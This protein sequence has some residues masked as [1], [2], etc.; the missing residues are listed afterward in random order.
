MPPKTLDQEVSKLNDGLV[1]V[2][3][4]QTT[5]IT[6]ITPKEQGKTWEYLP[7][8]EM[9]AT[10][11][12][13]KRL[14]EFLSQYYYWDESIS[15]VTNEV[16]VVDLNQML[17]EFEPYEDFYIALSS[18]FDGV[19]TI[20]TWLEETKQSLPIDCDKN[21]PSLK[22]LLASK[23][24][25]KMP[26]SIYN[27]GENLIDKALLEITEAAAICPYLGERNK[28]FEEQAAYFEQHLKEFYKTH[29]LIKS[30]MLASALVNKF[31]KMSQSFYDEYE[32]YPN[33]EHINQLNNLKEFAMGREKIT[34][35]Y[36]NHEFRNLKEVNPK[37]QEA[38]S[39]ETKGHKWNIW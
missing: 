3:V 24:Q 23:S 33:D 25:I 26:L 20:R 21:R 39:Q 32:T 13:Y 1:S 31:D 38:Q 30:I 16:K 18:F 4:G 10:G 34:F 29:G 14:D 36:F 9:I 17:S 7:V 12:A 37:K 8:N 5:D 15:W 35:K 2:E 11:V 19:E 6:L 28:D 22:Y 27:E